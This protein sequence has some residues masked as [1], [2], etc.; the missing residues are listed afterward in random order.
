VEIGCSPKEL[1]LDERANLKPWVF[2][3]DRDLFEQNETC[4]IA[5][6][7]GEAEKYSNEERLE[8]LEETN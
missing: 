4:Q 2:L 7:L 1:Y 8:G 5:D 3:H 6:F